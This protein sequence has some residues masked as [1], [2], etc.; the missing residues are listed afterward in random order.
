[1]QSLKIQFSYDHATGNLMNYSWYT[2]LKG[3]PILNMS[4]DYVYSQDNRCLDGYQS[5][6]F[7]KPGA[8]LPVRRLHIAYGNN[9]INCLYWWAD[10]YGYNPPLYSYITFRYDAQGRPCN[11]LTQTSTDSLNWINKSLNR[12]LYHASDISTGADF[13]DYYAHPV[14]PF[15]DEFQPLSSPA[16]GIITQDQNDYWDG[17]SWVPNTKRSYCYLGTDRLL[18]VVDKSYNESWQ[19]RHLYLQTYNEDSLPVLYTLSDWYDYFNRWDSPY[20]QEEFVWEQITGS[21][22]NFIQSS[23]LSVSVSPNPFRDQVSLSIGSKD[24]SPAQIGIYNLKGQLVQSFG[25]LPGKTLVWDGTDAKGYKAAAGMYLLKVK[26]K[27]EQ[28]VR[29]LIRLK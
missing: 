4:L 16:W 14:N 25:L 29:K 27:S 5:L 28:L 12:I 1:M 11:I 22:D 15:M 8:L 17:H 24:V 18:A 9:A 21:E 20:Y 2:Y 6:Y 7:D 13:V 10:N 23:G 26:Q 3:R 19:N